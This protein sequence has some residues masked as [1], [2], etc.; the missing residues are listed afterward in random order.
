[1]VISGELLIISGNS[2]YTYLFNCT[3]VK[4]NFTDATGNV[5]GTYYRLSQRMNHG[6]RSL[7]HRDCCRKQ[8]AHQ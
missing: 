8:C 2:A 3:G 6:N 1:M 4:V 7:F 5:K